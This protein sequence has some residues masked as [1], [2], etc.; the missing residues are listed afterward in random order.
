MFS[1]NI[2]RSITNSAIVDAYS[3][4]IVI[5]T[6][7]TKL[8]SVTILTP[9]I[10]IF[11][12]MDFSGGGIWACWISLARFSSVIPKINES[13]RF[14]NEGTNLWNLNFNNFNGNPEIC[15]G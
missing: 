6:V 11:V 2:Y 14:K 7:K 4:K 10:A 3:L 12:I 15:Q 8:T 13:K 9:S 1:K 5:L